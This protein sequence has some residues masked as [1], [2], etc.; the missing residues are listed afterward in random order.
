[1]KNMKIFMT[2]ASG[3]IGQQVANILLEKG[4]DLV[5]LTHQK[6]IDNARIKTVQGNILD[7]NSLIAMKGCDAVIAAA[8]VYVIG[9][10]KPVRR[11][12]HDINVTGAKNTLDL[13]VELGIPKIVYV[14]SI[15]VFNDTTPF[16]V[17]SEKDLGNYAKPCWT[18]YGQTK[19]D[20]HIYAQKL[21][22]EKHAPIVIAMPS[23]VFGEDDHS[24]TDAFLKQIV[25]GTLMG[26]IQFKVS[27]N[28][29]YVTD[30]AQGI[31][32]CLEKGTPGPYIIGGPPENNLNPSTFLEKCAQAGG[33][34]LPKRSFSVRAL[35]IFEKFYR[36]R[37][38]I[39][40]KYETVNA[41]LIKMNYSN[42]QVSNAKAVR[43]LG[44]QPRPIEE[45]IQRT[46]AWY[47]QKYDKR[48]A[49]S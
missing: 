25:Q 48:V 5:C 13:A 42:L 35:S 30:V 22:D 12:M 32:L 38:A 14:S 7:K 19:R 31:V 24:V 46:M 23:M 4:H 37:G 29:N 33:Y 8:A 39:T 47:K 34:Q 40:G 26:Q 28:F 20:A 49:E 45:G 41:E 44:Y 10:T 1:M 36:L 3:F 17:A 15:V 11:T 2:G 43:E 21:I 18:L 27:E 6:S 9:P 16:G